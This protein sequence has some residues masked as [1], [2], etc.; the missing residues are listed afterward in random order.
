MM[1]ITK[2]ILTIAVIGALSF[3]SLP[4]SQSSC[5]ADVSS[6]KKAQPLPT[7]TLLDQEDN[8][9]SVDTQITI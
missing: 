9:T 3:T 1:S 8:S 5:I 7:H 4:K 6:S 2:A